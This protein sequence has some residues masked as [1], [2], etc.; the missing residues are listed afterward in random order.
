[1]LSLKTAKGSKRVRLDGQPP[2]LKSSTSSSSAGH[3]PG[4]LGGIISG[5]PMA[6]RSHGATRSTSR[7]RTSRWYADLHYW[8]ASGSATGSLTHGEYR[9]LEL[10][11]ALLAAILG[12][13]AA[14]W[15]SPCLP[16]MSRDAPPDRA[17]GGS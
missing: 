13:N 5:T 4:T 8:R 11:P 6:R 15:L 7:S 9:G 14:R 2:A 10:P 1:M 17:Q 3:E 12:D 16:P